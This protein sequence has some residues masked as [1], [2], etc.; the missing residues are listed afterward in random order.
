[1]MDTIWIIYVSIYLYIYILLYKTIYASPLVGMA[2]LS[3]WCGNKSLAK[4]QAPCLKILVPER[5][6]QC[7]NPW[8]NRFRIHPDFLSWPLASNFGDFKGILRGLQQ[9]NHEK[10]GWIR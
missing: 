5:I 9:S 4:S 6:D 10:N 8:S 2:D 3:G 7:G 1:M